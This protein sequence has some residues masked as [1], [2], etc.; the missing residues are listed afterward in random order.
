MQDLFSDEVNQR[1][2]KSVLFFRKLHQ[3]LQQ[4]RWEHDMATEDDLFA[5]KASYV[6]TLLESASTPGL[7]RRTGIYPA[8]R[9]IR[10]PCWIHNRLDYPPSVVSGRTVLL[11]C[12]R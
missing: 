7:K 12:S 2:P 3:I 10:Y 6:G 1:A 5:V 4:R 9:A 11:A 8:R